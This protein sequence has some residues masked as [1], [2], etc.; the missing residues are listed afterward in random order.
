LPGKHVNG[1]LTLGENI[2]DLGGLNVAFDALQDDLKKHPDRNKS[3]DGYTPDQ[4]FFLNFARVWR[5]SI[6]PQRQEVLLNSDPHAPAKFRAIAAPSNMPAFAGAFQCKSGDEM[7][8]E[9][10]KHVKIW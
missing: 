5:G 6:L 2:A 10:D 7:L 8:R 3:V 9:G 1:K 4:R